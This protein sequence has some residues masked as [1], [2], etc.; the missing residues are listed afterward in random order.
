M[1]KSTTNKMAEW[2]MALLLQV[3]ELLKRLTELPNLA[4]SAVVRDWGQSGRSG[5][6]V[7]DN[8]N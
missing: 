2:S 8:L 1:S 6:P 3:M 7:P 4:D 5:I